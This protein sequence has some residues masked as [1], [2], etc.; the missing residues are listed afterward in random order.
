MLSSNPTQASANQASHAPAAAPVSKSSATTPV[1]SFTDDHHDHANSHTHE[2]GCTH[3]H[4]S[5][6][7]RDPKSLD[8]AGTVPSG[9]A[10][11]V[12]PPAVPGAVEAAHPTFISSLLLPSMVRIPP[13]PPTWTAP[14]SS[15]SV[16]RAQAAH[17]QALQAVRTVA[18]H[19]VL[20]VA[21]RTYAYDR[22]AYHAEYRAV[23]AQ[24]AQ[25]LK[26]VGEAIQAM[27]EMTDPN[28]RA[29][30]VRVGELEKRKLAV[31]ADYQAKVAE[32]LHGTRDYAEDV[33]R[34]DRELAQLRGEIAAAMEEFQAW[35]AD[36]VLGD[37]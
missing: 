8:S 25:L 20:A 23:V 9:L 37:E 32:T 1:E 33:S 29:T 5:L 6:T 31:T 15:G 30:V 3:D 7:V 28:L 16:S 26:R 10:H 34:L 14:A 11:A 2:C 22:P 4:A 17:F 19:R 27:G 36:L 18:T 24:V 21:F 35:Y 12:P 13:M